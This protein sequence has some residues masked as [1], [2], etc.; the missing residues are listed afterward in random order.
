MIE[1]QNQTIP[2]YTKEDIKVIPDLIDAVIVDM[3]LEKA[4]VIFGD[5]ADN[6][7]NMMITI[8]CE[9]SEHNIKI[10]EHC[11]YFE[12][13]KVPDN[14]KLAKII[15]FYKGMSVGMKVQLLKN[16]QGFFDLRK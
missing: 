11:T 6:P 8:Y 2:N 12:K 10:K 13:G 14:S 9:N 4:G 3:Q 5:K 7:S 16:G 1:E 15:D